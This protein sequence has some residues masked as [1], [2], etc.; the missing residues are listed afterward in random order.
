MWRLVF[1]HAG[2]FEGE[3]RSL[4]CRP[5][6]CWAAWISGI[7]VCRSRSMEKCRKL[8]V[9][10]DLVVGVV[11]QREVAT[12]DVRPAEG[13][14]KAMV[15]VKVSPQELGLSVFGQ[16]AQCKRGRLG[17][18]ATEAFDLLVANGWIDKHRSRRLPRQ[19]PGLSG[20]SSLSR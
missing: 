1:I 11:A 12:V 15:R 9:A 20:G 4:I 3:A 5:A 10:V 16:L 2:G 7:S 14:A 8:H 19:R 6:A 18:S 17:E 13:V